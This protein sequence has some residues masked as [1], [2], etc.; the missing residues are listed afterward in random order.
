[1]MNEA[2]KHVTESLRNDKIDCSTA[3]LEV[4]NPTQLMVK[5][6]FLQ[7]HEEMRD[8]A[9]RKNPKIP[10]LGEIL[11]GEE[12]RALLDSLKQYGV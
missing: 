3:V 12:V 2:C 8:Y 10:R 6:S 5:K 7:L 9:L 1:M 11:E 4:G